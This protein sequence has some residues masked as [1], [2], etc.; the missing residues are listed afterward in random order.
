MK[1]LITITFHYNEAKLYYLKR[2][3]DSIENIK[4]ERT[5]I[6]ISV[7]D[8]SDEESKV[9]L[10]LNE[11]LDITLNPVRRLYHPFFLAWA[12]KHYMLEFLDSDEFSHFVYLEDDIEITQTTI[13]YW[14]RTRELFKR[15]NLKFIPSI[16]R[17]EYDSKGDK[18]CVDSIRSN[19]NRPIINIEKEKFISIESPYQAMFIMD[20]EL[21]KE[22]VMSRSYRYETATPFRGSWL[23]QDLA[24]QGNMFENIPEGFEH[25]MLLSIDNYSDSLVH[26][27][28][29]TYVSIKD[30]PHGKLPINLLF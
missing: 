15:N 19:K 8:I 9:I 24:S 6:I 29:D 25:R 30:H 7:N 1:F 21:V 20:R 10:S 16:I 27:N 17:I 4:T 18:F 5:K 22:H 14:I 28:T 13:D 12:H 23:I 26:H 3:L 11:N 2:V